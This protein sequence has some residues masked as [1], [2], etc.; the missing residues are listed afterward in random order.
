MNS[1][2]KEIYLRKCYD[3]IISALEKGEA[4]GSP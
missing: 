3:I 4:G 1:V 2:K